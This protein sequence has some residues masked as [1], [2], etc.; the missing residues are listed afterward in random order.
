MLTSAQGFVNNQAAYTTSGS[1][2]Q[3]MHRIRGQ[4][5]TMVS[6]EVSVQDR[7]PGTRLYVDAK[8]QEYA[9]GMQ[10]VI[11]NSVASSIA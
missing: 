7:K 10:V 9:T 11:R 5:V 1:K 3:D 4:S 8:R 6:G 2:Q